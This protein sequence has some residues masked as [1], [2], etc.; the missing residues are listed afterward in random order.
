MSLANIGVTSGLVFLPLLPCSFEHILALARLMTSLHLC[1]SLDFSTTWSRSYIDIQPYKDIITSALDPLNGQKG[2]PQPEN[3][4]RLERS[5]EGGAFLTVIQSNRFFDFTRECSNTFNTDTEKM[6]CRLGLST[7][8][9][10]LVVRYLD[11][12]KCGRK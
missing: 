10:I 11:E 3:S 5:L 4:F 6:T 9:R 8:S 7:A 2:A 12:K 1:A